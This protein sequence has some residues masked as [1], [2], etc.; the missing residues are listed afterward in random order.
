MSKEKT[1]LTDEEREEIESEFPTYRD[2]KNTLNWLITTNKVKGAD[3]IRLEES[4]KI[5]DLN[6]KMIRGEGWENQKYLDEIES[7]LR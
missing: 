2:I 6:I 7:E 5:L 1:E 4:I 3:R